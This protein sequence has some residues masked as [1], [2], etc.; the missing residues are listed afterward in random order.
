M[1]GGKKSPPTAAEFAG[2]DQ[3]VAGSERLGAG[4]QQLWHSLGPH[5]P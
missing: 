3:I 2:W 1:S 4:R 5:Q